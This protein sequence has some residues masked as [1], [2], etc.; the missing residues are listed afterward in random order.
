MEIVKIKEELKLALQRIGGRAHFKD[1][2]AEY[3]KNINYKVSNLSIIYFWRL[4][5]FSSI[6]IWCEQ[7]H[8]AFKEFPGH[9]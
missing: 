1:L 5:K 8:S 2:G 3:K 9:I 7:L 6:E 4:K